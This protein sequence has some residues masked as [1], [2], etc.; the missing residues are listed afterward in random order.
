[1]LKAQGVELVA[2]DKPDAFLDDTPT[3]NLIRQ[4]LGAVSE[5]EKAM[6]VSKLKGARDRKRATGVKVEGRKSYSDTNPEMVRIAK[7]LHRYSAKG[8]RRSLR[9]VARVLASSGFVTSAGKPFAAAA[10]AKMVGA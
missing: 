8:R 6:V 4:V 10:V 5:F 9:E 1:M 7:R 3:A 2:T